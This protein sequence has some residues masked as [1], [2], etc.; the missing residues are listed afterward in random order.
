MWESYTREQISTAYERLI[1]TQGLIDFCLRAG[2]NI[3]NDTIPEMEGSLISIF[4][5]MKD[6]LEGTDDILG[7]LDMGAKERFTDVFKNK[8]EA[9]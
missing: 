6:Y 7:D 9:E 1:W 5:I 4:R 2:F 3:R 8:E